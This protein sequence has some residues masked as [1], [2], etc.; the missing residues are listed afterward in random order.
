MSTSAAE[1]QF[2]A[3]FVAFLVAAA[4][5]ALVILGADLL[6][7]VLWAR[8]LLALGF[9][10]LIAASFAHGSL[11]AGDNSKALIATVRAIGLAGV[12][13]GSVRWRGGPISRQFLWVGL[14]IT[15]AAVV[16]GA[17]GPRDT[18]NA[19]LI[20]G[21][22]GMGASLVI[23][24]RRSLAAR[25]AASAGATLLLL[26]LVLSV[27]LSAV[28]SRSTER[29]AVK[30]LGDT[31]S[32]QAETASDSSSNIALQNARYAAGL[33]FATLGQNLRGAENADPR[34]TAPTHAAAM[35]DSAI[36]KVSTVLGQVGLAFIQPKGTVLAT[37]TRFDPAAAIEVSQSA[38]VKQTACPSQETASVTM[39]HGEAFAVAARPIC[40]ESEHQVGTLVSV[41]AFN[42]SYLDLIAGRNGPTLALVGR[43]GLLTTTSGDQPGQDVLLR[44]GRRVLESGTPAS[45]VTNTRFVSARPVFASDRSVVAALIGS[46]PSSSVAGTRDDLFQ[47]L[48]LIALGG[49]L[50]ALLLAAIVGD[51][52]SGSLRRLTGAAEAIQRGDLD[53]RAGIDSEDE[54]GVL[55]AAFDSM[56]VS[57]EEKTTALRDAADAEAGLRNRL[58][59]VVA[60]V[61]DALVAV[62]SDGFVTDFNRAAEELTGVSAAVA[63]GRPL[64]DSVTLISDDGSDLTG[65]AAVPTPSR[66]AA[67]GEI[68]TGDGTRA[69]VAVSV[70]AV[71]GPGSELIG[72]VLVA[73]DL[74]RE[75]E[76][77]RMKTEFL[78][79][80]GHELR[81]PLTGIIGYSEILLARNVEKER[82]RLWHEEILG[83]SKR[84]LRI[85]E[86]LEF[87]ASAG[88][89]R[90]LLRPEAIDVR[91][92]V[93][94]V[95]NRWSTRVGSHHSIAR[96]VAK[97]LPPVVADRRWLTLSLDELVDNAVKFSPDGGRVLVTAAPSE[98]GDRKGVEIAVID[99]GQGM[100]LAE[101]A[102]AFGDF[103]QGDASDTRR[104]GGLGLGLGL[105]KRVVEG[106]G[107]SVMC[108]SEPNKGSRFT[109]FLPA[110]DE[111]RG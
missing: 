83:A 100:T 34:D 95:T 55:S 102:E 87:V 24:S 2:A 106:H 57:I 68:T 15:V 60:G 104:F 25:V 17:S 49:T 27:G 74:R 22:V 70:G 79:R 9:A 6:A 61:G 59:A 65:R 56:V 89:G 47:T 103:V 40:T 108:E 53:V 85:V 13:A 33:I 63:R 98:D 75:R 41:I 110:T 38:I 86:M 4:G 20:A 51:R 93:D 80:V 54:V 7:R 58:E 31:V 30:R 35:V 82:Q 52:I 45:T 10:G 94:E 81:T 26:V 111:A 105:V 11:L 88:A 92:V 14:A 67:I 18:A 42:R 64:S 44:L 39:L 32:T 84:L 16:I 28:L 66:W 29:E 19:L 50:A 71:R 78:S 107:G 69:P 99:R 72:S 48:F 8:V 43:T 91:R 77:E 46:Q 23:A 90:V 3:E 21:A 62:D 109:I 36:K 12:A 5:L 73:R 76:V 37:N 1:F 97:R 101:Q 96:R